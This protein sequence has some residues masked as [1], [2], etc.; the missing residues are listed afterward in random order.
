MEA[1]GR[2]LAELEPGPAMRCY[3]LVFMVQ[4]LE[5]HPRSWDSDLGG[6]SAA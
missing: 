6:G 2:T 1:W 4:E 3:S 5:E